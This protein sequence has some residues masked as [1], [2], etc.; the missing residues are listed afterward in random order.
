MRTSASPSAS[1]PDR[2]GGDER[3]VSEVLGFLLIFLILS[4]V[5]VLSMLAF[6]ALHDRAEAQVVELRA[7][8]VAQRVAASAVD[9]ALFAEGHAVST[10]TYQHPI[11]LP[12]DLEGHGYRVYLDASPDEQVRVVVAGL[13]IEVTA[14]L[15]SA[16]A[17]TSFDVCDGDVAGG[18]IKVRF[19]Q[20]PDD[21]VAPYDHCVFL[22]TSA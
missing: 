22:E 6:N 15:F 17:S 11:D 9:A 8:S 16:G 21:L 3:A 13:S 20:D 2:P 5:L 18:A 4:I 12:A 14:P 10:S 1:S 19:G 7:Q